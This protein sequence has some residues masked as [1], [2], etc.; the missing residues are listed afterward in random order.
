MLLQYKLST[1]DMQLSCLHGIDIMYKRAYTS[2]MKDYYCLLAQ[3][4]KAMATIANLAIHVEAC[5]LCC[6]QAKNHCLHGG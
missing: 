3:V 1:N 4:G 2:V 6:Y 5:P